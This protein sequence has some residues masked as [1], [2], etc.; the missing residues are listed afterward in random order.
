MTNGHILRIP[1]QEIVRR[2]D[3]IRYCFRCRKHRRFDYVVDA[4]IVEDLDD[5]AAY[6]P[7]NPHIEC[8]ECGERDSDLFP[9]RERE[10]ED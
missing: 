3:G 10:W 6:Y 5:T 4:P 2:P 7:P 1:T 9:G 8:T